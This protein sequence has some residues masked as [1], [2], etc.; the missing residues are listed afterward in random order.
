MARSVVYFLVGIL[1]LL[2]AVGSPYGATTDESGVFHKILEQRFGPNIVLAIGSG[3]LCYAVWRFVQTT[4][5]HDRYGRSWY[6]LAVRS[7][8]FGSGIAH[9]FFGLYALNLI[10]RWTHT[11]KFGE[12]MMAKWMMMQPFGRF[13]LFI[14]GAAVVITGFVQ[15]VRAFSGAFARD[16]KFKRN[17]H[18]VMNICRFGLV[19]RGVVFT[20]IGMFFIQAAWTYHSR[21]AGGLRKAWETLRDRPYGNFLV[22]TVAAGFMSFAVFSLIEGFYRKRPS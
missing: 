6:G 18:L 8:L 13:F 19:A 2:T 3:L 12:R 7:G 11:T 16:L 14:I 10:F 4:R 22:A 21:E 5:D 20:I 9:L 17:K 1:A 15:F